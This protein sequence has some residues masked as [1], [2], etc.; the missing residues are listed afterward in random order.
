MCAW[1]LASKIEDAEHIYNAL[2]V[3]KCDP[4]EADDVGKDTIIAWLRDH[5]RWDDEINGALPMEVITI[6]GGGSVRVGEPK[7]SW[8]A[9]GCKMRTRVT[10]LPFAL[11]AFQTLKED[12]ELKGCVQLRGFMRHYV[13]SIKTVKDSIEVM[14]RLLRGTESLR[15]E[16]EIDMQ[17]VMNQS[18]HAFSV[19][20]CGCM[21]GKIY[22]ECCGKFVESEKH[23]ETRQSAMGQ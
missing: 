6:D 10:H 13:L 12:D 3:M 17:K 14:G 9:N 1:W 7:V 21:S 8:E 19:R 15:Q 11:E 22:V 5:A 20:K 16:L 23:K 2:D 18:E 4:I